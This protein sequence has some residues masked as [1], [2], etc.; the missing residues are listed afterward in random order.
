MRA[1]KCRPPGRPT[2]MSASHW[3][4]GG[5]AARAH[6]ECAGCC[7]A[8][9]AEQSSCFAL[10]HTCIFMDSMEAWRAHPTSAPI[11]LI[12]NP[13]LNIDPAAA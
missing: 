9:C 8:D 13:N 7:P 6:H 2:S 4:K 12:A 5:G 3:W 1:P 11:C 10:L